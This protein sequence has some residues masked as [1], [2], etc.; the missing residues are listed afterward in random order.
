MISLVAFSAGVCAQ[1]NHFIYIQTENSLPFYVRMSGKVISSSAGGYVILPRLQ[2]GEHRLFIGFPK[3]EFPEREYQIGLN[4]Q[5]EGFLLKKLDNG[6]SLFNIESLALIDGVAVN[7]QQPTEKKEAGQKNNPFTT[8][9]ATVVQDS[10]LLTDNTTGKNSTVIMDSAQIT[11]VNMKVGRSDS[12]VAGMSPS[13]IPVAGKPDSLI[14]AN[15]VLVPVADSNIHLSDS[16]LAGEQMPDSQVNAQKNAPADAVTGKRIAAT[17]EKSSLDISRILL[18]NETGGLDLVYV[19]R[20][21]KD[22]IRLFMPVINKQPSGEKKAKVIYQPAQ[23]DTSSLTITPTIVNA[24]QTVPVTAEPKNDSPSIA[25]KITEAPSQIQ[26]TIEKDS[27][28]KPEVQADDSLTKADTPKKEDTS[29]SQTKTAQVIYSPV[30]NSDCKEVAT[31][32]DFLKLRK[33]MV[34]E[35]GD[36]NMVEAARKFFRKKCY[37][38]EQIRELSYIFLYDEGKYK[39]FDAAYPY[40]SDSNQYFTL[41]FQLHDP[42]YINRFKAMIHK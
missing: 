11:G 40:A 29:I 9:L 7:V 3:N 1:G 5:D 16:S 30:V 22:T 17:P 31:E 41:E 24:P 21:L 35:V 27:I 32:K 33:K 25:D 2:D 15:S 13:E 4:G 19:D 8:L 6:W 12:S 10:S 36:D 28:R 14:S 18:V 26:S 23:N 39:F 20:K 37:T 34:T 38:V 42:Y